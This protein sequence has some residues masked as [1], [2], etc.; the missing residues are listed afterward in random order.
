MD[1]SRHRI[2]VR[3]RISFLGPLAAAL[4]LGGCRSADVTYL[5]LIDQ[6]IEISRPPMA[7]AQA[8]ASAVEAPSGIYVDTTGG[9][10]T[11]RGAGRPG[12]ISG[13]VAGTDG[14]GIPHALISF[15]G[16]TPPEDEEWP[17]FQTDA[18]GAF[19][20]RN[21]P[22]GD[23]TIAVLRNGYALRVVRGVHVAEGRATGQVDITLNPSGGEQ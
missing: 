3:H 14:S 6:H 7:A 13:R 9:G 15:V 23:Y 20:I 21:I 1:S 22:P 17:S 8:P 11:E 19:E 10:A 12:S 4:L 5:G 2:T 18:S 16:G